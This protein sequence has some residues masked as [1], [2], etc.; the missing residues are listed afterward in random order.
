MGFRRM[1]IRV[2]RSFALYKRGQEFD[3]PDGMARLLVR[4]GMIEEVKPPEVEEA[5]VEP[6]V[7]TATVKRGRSPRK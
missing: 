6:E 4:Q 1:K 3:W 2:V 7:E 5:A